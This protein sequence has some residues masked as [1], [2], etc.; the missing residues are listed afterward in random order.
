[1]RWRER[2]G[3]EMKREGRTLD[4]ERERGEDMRWRE[5]GEDIRWRERGEDMRWRER[6]EDIR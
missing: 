6:G 3:H 2:G 1:M 5:R 4:E